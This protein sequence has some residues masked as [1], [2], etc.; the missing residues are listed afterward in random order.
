M[1][2]NIVNNDFAPAIERGPDS[3]PQVTVLEAALVSPPSLMKAPDQIIAVRAHNQIAQQLKKGP[4][5]R[6]IRTLSLSR[7]RSI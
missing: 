7:E 3:T 5:F 6:T 2:L 1:R 4:N